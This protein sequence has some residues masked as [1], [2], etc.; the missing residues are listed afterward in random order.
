M[1][2]ELEFKH[3]IRDTPWRTPHEPQLQEVETYAPPQDEIID[4]MVV[5]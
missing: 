5:E 4:G 1:L 3:G 2:L